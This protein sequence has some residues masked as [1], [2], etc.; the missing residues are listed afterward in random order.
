MF[1]SRALPNTQL[2]PGQLY[3][4]NFRR[5]HHQQA[6]TIR[7]HAKPDASPPTTQKSPQ[8]PSSQ[9]GGF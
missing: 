4:S 9:A 5:K 2:S 3:Q 8:D 7:D 1:S 6:N